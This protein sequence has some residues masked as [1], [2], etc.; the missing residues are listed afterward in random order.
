[1]AKKRRQYSSEFKTEAIPLVLTAE[2]LVPRAAADLGIP[3]TVL[4]SGSPSP[5]NLKAWSHRRRLI[6]VVIAAYYGGVATA[7]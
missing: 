1:M 4:G 6:F 3:N 5:G 2:V 7:G